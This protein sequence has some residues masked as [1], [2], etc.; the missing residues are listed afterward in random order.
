MLETIQYQFTVCSVCAFISCT[1]ILQRAQKKVGIFIPNVLTRNYNMQILCVLC[2]IKSFQKQIQTYVLS[3]FVTQQGPSLRTQL[4]SP[5]TGNFWIKKWRN[6]KFTTT[7]TSLQP[8]SWSTV[9]SRWQKKTQDIIL[10]IRREKSVY[11][12][13]ISSQCQ[14]TN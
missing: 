5:T 6:M 1:L 9:I 3:G 10:E 11:K 14:E 13:Q 4:C 7:I 8:T 2:D 12:T